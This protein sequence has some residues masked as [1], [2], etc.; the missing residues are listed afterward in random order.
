[1]KKIAEKFV[2]FEPH[3][4]DLIKANTEF[5]EMLTKH[6]DKE[7]FLTGAIYIDTDKPIFFVHE[8]GL[9]TMKKQ[10]IMHLI[11]NDIPLKVIKNILENAVKERKGD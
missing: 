3:K 11:K 1:M 4:E 5:I 2:R 10:S 9:C 8:L 6:V 7:I